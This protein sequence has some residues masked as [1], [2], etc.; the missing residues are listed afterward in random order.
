ME[1][2]K[3]ESLAPPA[4]PAI[5]AIPEAK[6]SKIAT[7]ARGRLAK[8]ADHYSCDH[9][10]LL[11]WYRDDLEMVAEMPSKTLAWAIQ[12]YLKGRGDL[13]KTDTVSAGQADNSRADHGW[14][15]AEGTLCKERYE[16]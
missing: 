5:P 10:D 12:D 13:Y 4:I 8:A 7:I 3:F 16:R 6:N 2:F 1:K 11:S 15:H 9:D 14:A